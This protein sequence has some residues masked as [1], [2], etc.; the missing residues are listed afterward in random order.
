FDQF[1][2]DPDGDQVALERILTQPEAGSA[3]LSADGASIVYTSAPGDSGQRSFTYSVVD[4]A[5][6]SGTGVVRV[7]VLDAEANPSPVTFTDYVQ[8]QAGVGSAIRIS[9]LANDVDPTGGRLTLTDVRPDIPQTL[10]D[11]T[12]S[13]DYARQRNLIADVGATT[14]TI[15]AGLNPGTM[16]FL[17]DLTSDSGNTARDMIVVKVVR[18]AVTDYPVVISTVLTAETCDRFRSGVVVVSGSVTWSGGDVADLTLSLWGDPGGVVVDGRR[19]RGALPEH[20]RVIPFA[21]TG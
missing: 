17:Y 3:T 9:P 18:D 12:D 4:G 1:G 16:S 2:V 13:P 20:S 7:G 15:N 10:A 11:G 19:L 14:V 6:G 8:V 5:G 21:L